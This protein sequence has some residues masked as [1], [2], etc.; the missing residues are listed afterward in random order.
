[1]SRK[2]DTA[3]EADWSFVEDS[4]VM[5]A[6]K[7]AAVKAARQFELVE[8]D[9]A[10]QDALLFL[11][12][13]PEWVARVRAEGKSVAELGQTI[14]ANAL[15]ADAVRE[16]DWAARTEPLDGPQDGDDD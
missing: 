3:T 9:D 12:V 7:W 11:A 6:V 15:R 8:Y 13:R 1:M 2:V 16:S 10:E 14:Y 4:V 5:R